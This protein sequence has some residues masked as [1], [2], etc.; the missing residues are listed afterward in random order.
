MIRGLNHITLA[1]R[2]IEQSLAFYTKAMFVL[3]SNLA[4]ALRTTY[5]NLANSYGIEG[6]YHVD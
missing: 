2:D 5:H 1:V 4:L 3:L 6:Y